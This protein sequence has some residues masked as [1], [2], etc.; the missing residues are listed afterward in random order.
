MEIYP[1]SCRQFSFKQCKN[2]FNNNRKSDEHSTTRNL[3]LD[4]IEFMQ[5]TLLSV[6]I[7]KYRYEILSDIICITFEI[8]AL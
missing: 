7:E 2:L 8:P 4:E 1:V 6:Q 3:C 5:I